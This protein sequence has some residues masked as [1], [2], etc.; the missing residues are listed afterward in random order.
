MLGLLK[1]AWHNFHNNY[2]ISIQIQ[3]LPSCN[4]SEVYFLFRFWCLVSLDPLCSSHSMT[5]FTRMSIFS[6][7]QHDVYCAVPKG[8]QY[9]T[10]VSLSAHLEHDCS[11]SF[12]FPETPIPACHPPSLPTGCN[13]HYHFLPGVQDPNGA[14]DRR[15]E[16]TDWWVRASQPQPSDQSC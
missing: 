3:I 13:H 6:S 4:S 1:M 16:W 10:T 7:V 15:L 2:T 8:K 9:K 5:P 12:P 14:D 11:S